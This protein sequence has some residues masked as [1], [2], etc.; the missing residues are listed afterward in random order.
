MFEIFG[1]FGVFLKWK[2]QTWEKYNY[3]LGEMI[4]LG[5]ICTDWTINKFL[6]DCTH[7]VSYIM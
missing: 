4:E 2:Y 6:A 3:K 7:L 1:N 5:T